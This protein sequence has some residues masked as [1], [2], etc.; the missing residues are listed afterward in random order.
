MM[1]KTKIILLLL[2]AGVLALSLSGCTSDSYREKKELNATDLSDLRLDFGS[3]EVS[4][5]STEEDPYVELYVRESGLRYGGKTSLDIYQSGGH[6]ELSLSEGNW[7][8]LMGSK[9]TKVTLYLPQD[10]VQ[11]L[12]ARLGSGKFTLT[13]L[14]FDSVTGNLSSGDMI[15]DNVKAKNVDFT[16]SSG[17]LTLRG[18]E[19]ETAKLNLSSGEIEAG[20]TGAETKLES[21]VS[22][23]EMEVSGNFTQVNA[24]N[25]SGE[26]SISSGLLPDSIVADVR[27]GEINLFVPQTQ[28]GFTVRYSTTSGYFKT[29]FVRDY[30]QEDGTL[31]VGEGISIFDFHI[32]SGEISLKKN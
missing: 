32:S 21:E 19:A 29:D 23:G 10:A 24:E 3:A 22:S 4:V 31:T 27:S 11:T 5:R 7:F 1:K 17:D 6:T 12:Y 15:F 13:G 16:V 28:E 8:F 2:C 9:D 30:D 20:F 25:K 18:I 26:T 14:N